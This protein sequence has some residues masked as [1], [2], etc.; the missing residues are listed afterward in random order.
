MTKAGRREIRR[1]V[2]HEREGQTMSEYKKSFKK[3]V[4]ELANL[5]ELTDE[6]VG[7]WF[8]RVDM[9]YQREGISYKEQAMLLKLANKITKGAKV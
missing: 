9:S 1:P 5:D 7:E 4:E 2:D 8:G 3:L 6:T